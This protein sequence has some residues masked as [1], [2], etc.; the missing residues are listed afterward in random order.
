MGFQPGASTGKNSES[1]VLFLDLSILKCME[2]FCDVYHF[3]KFGLHD[4]IFFCEMHQA[5]SSN[6]VEELIF[7]I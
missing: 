5:V 1:V 6:N 7:Y 2:S 4:L 3:C